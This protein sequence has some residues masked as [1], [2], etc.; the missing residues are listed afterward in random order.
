MS[1]EKS[2]GVDFVVARVVKRRCSIC[3]REFKVYLD[4]EGK[5]ISAEGVYFGKVKLGIGFYTVA[6]MTKDGTFIN[7][8]PWYKRLWYKLVDFFKLIFGL[9]QEVEVW[10]CN[11]CAKILEEIT[12]DESEAQK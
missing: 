11:R 8:L 6:K 4:N 7:V 1:E 2:Y 10:E 5:I 3:G 9:Y 12:K